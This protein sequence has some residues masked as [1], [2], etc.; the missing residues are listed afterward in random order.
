MSRPTV[1]D[2]VAESIRADIM[3]MQGG[4]TIPSIRTLSR[5]YGVARNT[6]QKALGI[7]TEHGAL[8]RDKNDR[9]YIRKR[10]LSGH[11]WCKPYPG[12]GIVSSLSIALNF[13]NYLGIL[14][15]EFI[16]GLQKN[17]LAVGL[18]GWPRAAAATILPGGASL[19]PLQ[20]RCSG[21]AF[22][23]GESEALHQELAQAG[24]LVM[25]LDNLSPVEGVDCVAV[26][27]PAEAEMVVD[28]LYGLG[29][30]AIALLVWRY[31]EGRAM[32][33]DCERL[34]QAMLRAKQDRGAIASP[35][36]HTECVAEK[37]RSAA[38]VHAAIARLWRLN[39]RPTA[40]VCF[41]EMLAQMTSAAIQERGLSCPSHVSI[42]ARGVE[43]RGTPHFT[44]L[45]AEPHRMGV[46]AAEHMVKRMSN[47]AVTATHLLFQSKLIPGPT[48]GPVGRQ[49]V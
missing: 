24:A 20:W 6:I 42:V 12:V 1:F 21:V 48:T 49:P 35:L 44:M 19:G 41:D 27:M 5:R 18:F 37:L 16:A 23:A 4:I 43:P 8:G 11:N 29:H 39:P 14:F 3:T 26:D 30:R 40:I 45:A 17:R 36:Y 15:S 46:A 7:L 47:P 32:D 9:R 31:P 38:P 34:S 28:Y 2:R 10:D 25:V 33:P 22:R 13:D